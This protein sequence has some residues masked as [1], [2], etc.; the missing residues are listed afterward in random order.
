MAASVARFVVGLPA[1]K[2]TPALS[3]RL[4]LT[5][6]AAFQFRKSSKQTRSISN[7][8]SRKLLQHRP[9]ATDG[10]KGDVGYCLGIKVGGMVCDGCSS[11]VEEALKAVPGVQAVEVTLDPG[12]ANVTV[13]AAAEP[14]AKQAL[15]KLTKIIA[16]LGFEV[17]A[18]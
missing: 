14:D 13:S 7:G 4:P 12:V 11:R 2:L 18:A 10:S 1:P 17:A 3:A 9:R 15:A 6:P 16:D 8:V 5:S